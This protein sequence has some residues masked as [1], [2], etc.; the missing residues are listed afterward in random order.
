M[1]FFFHTYHIGDV[2]GRLCLAALLYTVGQILNKKICHVL[3]NHLL[4][5]HRVSHRAAGQHFHSCC[6]PL[7]NSVLNEMIPMGSILWVSFRR[8]IPS[9][10]LPLKQFHVETE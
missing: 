1:H 8:K 9:L 6:F 2:G 10:S 5:P 3:I 4:L 7:Q